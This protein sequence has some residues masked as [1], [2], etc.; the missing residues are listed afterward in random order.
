M[1]R[2]LILIKLV[3]RYQ[4]YISQKKNLILPGNM[5]QTQ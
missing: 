5:I 4:N 2:Q 1:A 3:I